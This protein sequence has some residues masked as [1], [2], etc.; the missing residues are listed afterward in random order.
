M[1]LQCGPIANDDISRVFSLYITGI[2]KAEQLA[3]ELEYKKL[4]DQYS[5][6]TDKAINLLSKV[7]V[8]KY[9]N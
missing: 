9:G 1:I 6:H 4:N 8:E 7:G 5:F 2:I 3:S